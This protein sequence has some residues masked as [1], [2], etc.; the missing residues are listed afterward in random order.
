[1]LHLSL[2][3]L[4]FLPYPGL[5]VA[6][7]AMDTNVVLSAA[8][9]PNTL[10]SQPPNSI[11]KGHQRAA[12]FSL[13]RNSN[14]LEEKCILHD[15][16]TVLITSNIPTNQDQLLHILCFRAQAS[17]LH[18]STGNRMTLYCRISARTS[19]LSS[20]TYSLSM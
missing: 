19:E 13:I 14:K 12:A 4:H 6:D 8:F 10:P 2:A 20:K 7:V 15:D 17:E 11:L 3:Y 1:M 5:E 9:P 18:K 16:P